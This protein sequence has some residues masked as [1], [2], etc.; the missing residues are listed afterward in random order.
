MGLLPR[1]VPDRTAHRRDD[2]AVLAAEWPAL[3][4]LGFVGSGTEPAVWY[5]DNIKVRAP[6]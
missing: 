1:H 3:R 5:I 4:W 6:E 2:L